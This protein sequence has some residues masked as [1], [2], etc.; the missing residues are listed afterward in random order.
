MIFLSGI[1]LFWH[2]TNNTYLQWDIL[3][4]IYLFQYLEG[5]I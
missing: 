2:S 4:V 1:N 5:V 3:C